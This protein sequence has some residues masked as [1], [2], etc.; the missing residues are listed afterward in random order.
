[1]PGVLLRDLLE[2]LRLRYEIEK[3]PVLRTY[4]HQI[5]P[6]LAVLGGLMAIDITY[7]EILKYKALRLSQGAAAQ[8]L[9][10]ELGCIQRAFREGVKARKVSSDACPAIDKLPV[11]N[12]RQGFVE[13]EKFDEIREYL[14]PWLGHFAAFGYI[15]GWRKGEIA[16]LPWSAVEWDSD[17]IRLPPRLAKNREGRQFPL[18]GGV[19]EVLKER[20]RLRVPGLD[21]VFHRNG[22]PIRDFRVPWVRA[23]SRAGVHWLVFHDLRRSA[24]RNMSEAGVPERVIMELVGHKTRSMATRYNIV[25]ESRLRK[26]GLRGWIYLRERF[27]HRRDRTGR[28]DFPA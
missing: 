7:E 1:M 10:H 16:A 2:L 27:Q 19:R 17:I 9:N 15:T 13:P 25:D 8:T 28:S 11:D 21:L 26:W 4:I 23:V 3:R 5:K 6:I 24:W 18:V 12:A 22:R 14:P 20:E